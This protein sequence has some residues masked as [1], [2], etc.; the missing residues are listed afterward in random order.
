MAP[1][2]LTF[3]VHEA[4]DVALTEDSRGQ[5]Q[6]LQVLA[7]VEDLEHIVEVILLDASD[8]LLV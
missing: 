2:S 3:V 4:G 7:S 5:V 6:N 8:V 1:K